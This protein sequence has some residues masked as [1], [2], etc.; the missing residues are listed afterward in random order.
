MLNLGVE[1][2]MIVGAVVGFAVAYSAACR[3]SAS[4]A[5]ILA[6]AAMSAVFAFLTLGLRPIRSPPAWR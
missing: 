5:G 1:G 3:S 4:L 6:G 2:M